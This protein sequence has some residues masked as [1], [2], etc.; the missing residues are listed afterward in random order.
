MKK[1][2][3]SLAASAVLMMGIF[4]GCTNKEA[5]ATNS[6]EEI[7]SSGVLQVGTEGTY[8]PFTFHDETGKLTG[9]DVEIAEEVAKRLGVKAEF[10]ETK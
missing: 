7:K 3:L 4:A 6:L 5:T 10:I 8:A 1:R 2:I 9:F